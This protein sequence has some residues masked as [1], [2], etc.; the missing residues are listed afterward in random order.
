[1][2]DVA[3]LEGLK[4][5]PYFLIYQNGEQ[6]DSLQSGN[7]LLVKS[8]CQKHLEFMKKS[9]K[10]VINFFKNYLHLILGKAKNIS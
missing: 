9:K 5:V 2:Q 1:L 7:P 10:K 4:K 6:I 3:M 8:F